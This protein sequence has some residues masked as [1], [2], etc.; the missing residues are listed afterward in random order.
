M[1]TF[2]HKPIRSHNKSIHLGKMLM[3]FHLSKSRNN[4]NSISLKTIERT[5]GCL[6]KLEFCIYPYSLVIVDLNSKKLIKN[7]KNFVKI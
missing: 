3:T 7:K 2:N 5:L 4:F 1:I 6:L